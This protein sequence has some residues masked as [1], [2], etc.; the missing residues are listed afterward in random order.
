MAAPTLNTVIN[1]LF[2]QTSRAIDCEDSGPVAFDLLFQVLGRPFDH[3]DAAS[4]LT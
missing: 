1:D 2:D 4:A 3:G